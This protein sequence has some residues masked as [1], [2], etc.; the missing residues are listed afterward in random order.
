MPTDRAHSSSH[1]Q[2]IL[3]TQQ[4]LQR[5]TCEH[6]PALTAYARACAD[7]ANSCGLGVHTSEGGF[8]EEAM[9]VL[10]EDSEI[11]RSQVHPA[12]CR[13]EGGLRGAL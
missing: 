10:E 3:H 13:G 2:P 6:G 9:Q 11:P 7:P 4:G 5:M 12:W 1:R 8:G